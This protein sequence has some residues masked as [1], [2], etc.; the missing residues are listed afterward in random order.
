MSVG[1]GEG[2][3]D[4]REMKHLKA[5]LYDLE[6]ASRAKDMFINQLKEEREQFAK[7]RK[8]FVVQLVSASRRLGEIET[9]LLQIEPRPQLATGTQR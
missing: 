2:K 3:V 8:E 1:S 7:E 4:Q 6:I 5:K 9:R